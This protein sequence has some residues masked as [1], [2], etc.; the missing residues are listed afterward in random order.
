[1]ILNDKFEMFPTTPGCGYFTQNEATDNVWF[2]DD[3]DC[4][5]TTPRASLC[6]TITDP[7][8]HKIINKPH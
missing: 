7:G 4:G 3:V 2:N 6:D 1:M 8:K 5:E